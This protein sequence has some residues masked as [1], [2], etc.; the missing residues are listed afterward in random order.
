MIRGTPCNI[1]FYLKLHFIKSSSHKV[2]KTN[3][4]RRSS[5]ASPNV[6]PPKL[7]NRFHYSAD[8]TRNL[9]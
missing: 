7:F 3:V 9:Q 4:Q 1:L 5:S 6:T 8:D 2:N